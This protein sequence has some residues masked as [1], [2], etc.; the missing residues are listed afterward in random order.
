MATVQ[1]A[2]SANS[3]LIEIFKFV[4]KQSYQNAANL[5]KAIES[6]I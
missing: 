6:K 1:I 4:S 3:D 5:I 2:R